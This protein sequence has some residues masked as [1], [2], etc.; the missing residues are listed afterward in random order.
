MRAVRAQ[1]IP[2]PCRLRQA[3]LLRGN[4]TGV[5][6]TTA[7]QG[8]LLDRE[9]VPDRK[10]QWVNVGV[11]NIHTDTAR[12]VSATTAHSDLHFENLKRS[13]SVKMT[14]II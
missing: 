13:I 7:Q 2:A 11:K 4:P 9:T 8:I 6:Q 14:L 10:G 5:D 3:K 1:D 12:S